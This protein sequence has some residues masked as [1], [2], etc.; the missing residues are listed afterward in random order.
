MALHSWKERAMPNMPARI[1]TRLKGRNIT[2]TD[3]LGLVHQCK[4]YGAAGGGRRFWT[5]WTVCHR[6]APAEAVHPQGP[7]EAI[8]CPDCLNMVSE[9]ARRILAKRTVAQRPAVGGLPFKPDPE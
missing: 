3:R 8:T 5:F 9:P 7:G 1:V 4:G 2:Y 6:D